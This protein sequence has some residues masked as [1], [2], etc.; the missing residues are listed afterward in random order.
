MLLENGRDLQF[1]TPK[2]A[3]LGW[4]SPARTTVKTPRASLA[5]A[6]FRAELRRAGRMAW[7]RL[8]AATR[9]MHAVW[10][11]CHYDHSRHA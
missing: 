5:S 1:V 9:A 11:G 8:R 2:G 4:L 10:S 6:A 7:H 3:H